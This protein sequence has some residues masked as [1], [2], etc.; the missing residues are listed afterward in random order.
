M[1]SQQST[2]FE[3]LKKIWEDTKSLFAK[4]PRGYNTKEVCTSS[5]KKN[6][7]QEFERIGKNQ[8]MFH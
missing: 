1:D 4:G 3:F 2:L 7:L 5:I 6:G 8:I